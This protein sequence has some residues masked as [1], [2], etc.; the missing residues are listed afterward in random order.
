MRCKIPKAQNWLQNAKSAECVAKCQKHRTRRKTPK[1]K[2]G[3]QNA[4]SA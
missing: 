3:Q 1:A 4:K 2:N